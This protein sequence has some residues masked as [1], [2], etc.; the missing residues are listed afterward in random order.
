MEK[1]RLGKVIR[2]AGGWDGGI[3]VVFEPDLKE[4]KEL[5]SRISERSKWRGPKQLCARCVKD[6]QG[7]EFGW[8][9]GRGR[10]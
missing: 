6:N 8:S 1:I 10:H 2:N 7:G 5:A 3:E 4:Y 9:G